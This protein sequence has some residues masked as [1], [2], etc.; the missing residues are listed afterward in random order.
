MKAAIDEELGRLP[1]R[2]MDPDPALALV[3]IA[4]T[5]TTLAAMEKQLACY[6]QRAVHGS[7]LSKDAVTR[8]RRRLEGASI[9]ERRQMIGLEPQR[10]DVIFAGA[11]L[12]ERIMERHSAER[13]IVSDQGVRYGLLHEAARLL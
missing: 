13:V 2:G 10:A 9:A 8:Q 3:G 1:E 7:C 5:F 4:G 6:S 12:V 11:C